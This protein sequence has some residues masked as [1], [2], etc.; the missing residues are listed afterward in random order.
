MIQVSEV[1]WN[2]ARSKERETDTHPCDHYHHDSCFC[3]GSCSCHWI[4]EEAFVE[5]L[6]A[7]IV[8]RAEKRQSSM[9]PL[10]NCMLAA[11]IFVLIGVVA[12]LAFAHGF[13]VRSEE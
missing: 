2:K 6:V 5:K 10:D 1:E 7:E 3:K 9:P 4:T 12:K 11:L 8:A 13:E